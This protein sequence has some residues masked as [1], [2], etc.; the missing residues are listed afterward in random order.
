M[1]GYEERGKYSGDMLQIRL[2]K[3]AA[4]LDSGATVKPPLPSESVTVAC[5]DHLVLA[6]LPV[7]KSLGAITASSGSSQVKSVGRRSRRHLGERVHFCVCCDHPI[8]IY[9]RLVRRV[10]SFLSYVVFILIAFITFQFIRL[11]PGINVEQS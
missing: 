9:G 7:A 11:L 4:A 6:D 8:A 1:G 3:G 10:L 2:N 5:P